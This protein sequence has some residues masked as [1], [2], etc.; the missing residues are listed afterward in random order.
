MAMASAASWPSTASPKAAV[1]RD[2][3]RTRINN[4]AAN[5][6]SGINQKFAALQE[7]IIRKNDPLVLFLLFLFQAWN[8]FDRFPIDRRKLQAFCQPFDPLSPRLAV[9]SMTGF[10]KLDLLRFR[11]PFEIAARHFFRNAFVLLA[12]LEKDRSRRAMADE[13]DPRRVDYAAREEKIEAA[14]EI[15]HL[16]A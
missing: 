11:E 2:E 1:R 4:E 8:A 7:I 16:L 9:Q 14:P 10:V 6:S 15:D 5:G 3:R 12:E 13:R